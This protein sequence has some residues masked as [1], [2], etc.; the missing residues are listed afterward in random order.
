MVV[1]QQQHTLNEN[2]ILSCSSVFV[3]YPQL[4]VVLFVLAFNTL[5]YGAWLYAYVQEVRYHAN[6]WYVLRIIQH[7]VGVK[8]IYMDVASSGKALPQ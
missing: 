8:S 6:T 5:M 7:C 4:M 3:L 1:E 2:F